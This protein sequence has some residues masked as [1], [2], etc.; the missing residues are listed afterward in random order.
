MKIPYHII[1]TGSQGNA[2][3]VNKFVLIDCGVPFK[4]LQPF[5]RDLK[6]V[7][8]THIHSDHFNKSAIKQLA[9]DRPT[10]RFACGSWLAKAVAD[11]GVPI[12]QMDVLE[13]QTL[14]NYGACNISMFL[15]THDV[16]NCGWK[17][18]FPIG[19][20][21][22]ATDCS[23]L[24]GI[25]ALHYDLFLIEANYTTAEIEAKIA[26]K[27][28]NGEYAYEVR[29]QRYHLSKEKCDDFI[30][31]NIGKNGDYVYMHTH[32]DKE[33]PTDDRKT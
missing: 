17:I 14:Y 28:A 10:L 21:I 26:E 22:Y 12:K 24:N 9:A 11:C 27:K 2:T 3:I 18:H 33:E 16:P 15:T 7:L 4:Q 5:Y 8:L 23:N 31:R 29:A 19:K 1:S 25:S 20:C 6:I 13:P 32:R 30:C